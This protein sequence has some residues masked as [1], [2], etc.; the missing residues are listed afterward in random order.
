MLKQELQKEF[1]DRLVNGAGEVGNELI[2]IRV[3]HSIFAVA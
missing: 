1:F 3:L 2:A